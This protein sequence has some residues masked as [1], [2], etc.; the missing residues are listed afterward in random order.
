MGRHIKAETYIENADN[1]TINEKSLSLPNTIPSISGF[2]G[3]EDYLEEIRKQY[4]N[5]IRTFVFHGIGGVGK[6]ALALEFA[7]EIIGDFESNISV[8]MRG[9]SKDSLSAKDAKIEVIKQFEPEFDITK[10]DIDKK[11]TQK[12]KDTPTI[13]IL[14]NAKDKQAVES[15]K[16]NVCLIVTSRTAFSLTSGMSI[17]I[18]K[19][20]PKDAEKLLFEIADEERFAGKADTLADLAGYLPMALKPLASILKE[21][22][23]ETVDDLIKKFIDKQELLKARVPDYNNLTIEASFELS[24]ETLPDEMKKR[25]LYLSVFPSDFNQDALASIL[26]ISEDKAKETQKLLRRFSLLE[27]NKEAFRFNLHDLVRTYCNSKVSQDELFSIQFSFAKYY[28]SILW[29]AQNIKGSGKENSFLT[30]LNLIDAEWNNILSGQKWSAE[31]FEITDEIARICIEYSQVYWDINLRL[32][33]QDIIDW[34]EAGYKACQ[35]IGDKINESNILGSLGTAHRNLG[36][37]GKAMDFYE[38]ALQISRKIGDRISEGNNLANL[39]TAYQSLGEYIKAIEFHEQALS[40]L[41]ET[42]DYQNEDSHLG[43][44]GNAYFNLGKFKKASDYYKQSLK[45]SREKGDR[46]REGSSLGNLGNCYLRLGKPQK[47]IE[48]FEQALSISREIGDRRAEA[49]WLGNLGNSFQNLSEYKKAIEYF[50]KSLKISKEISDRNDEASGL[51][52]LGNA[53]RSLGKFRRAIRYYK[54]ALIISKEIGDRRGEGVWLGSLG[55]VYLFLGDNSKAI[56]FLKQNLII[57]KEIG[58]H[59]GEGNCFGHLGNVFQNLGNPRKAIEYF[60]WALSISIELGER[61]GEATWLGSLG[62]AFQSLGEYKKAIEYFNQ[63]LEISIELGNNQNV[64]SCLGNLGMSY[65]SL[66][67]YGKAVEYHRQAL[68][69]AR[70]IGDRQG[71]GSQLGNLGNSYMNLGEKEKACN[72]WKEALTIFEEIESPFAK[73]TRQSLAS[74]CS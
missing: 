15:L 2:V 31:N 3:R 17:K 42:G 36:N 66:R 20:S 49:A 22:E 30:A 37:F 71:E 57:S 35:R 55:N 67:E 60:E 51:G 5:G 12:V 13:I 50:D 27:V 61:Q 26:E 39:G 33:S 59:R 14:D 72:F 32:H 6:S 69:I 65:N 1:F 58:D 54:K 52:N 64:G 34:M 25:W 21:D 11:F 63:T 7:N 24:Y 28:T 41:R 62:I 19:M 18:E 44:L 68:Q 47:A 73:I 70:K 74:N 46:R 38:Q 16:E 40:I 4:Q 10:L 56:K 29:K 8:S 23:L 48:H 9:M 53:Y 43:N 45:I